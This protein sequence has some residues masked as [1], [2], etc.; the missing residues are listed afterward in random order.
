MWVKIIF[1]HTFLLMAQ[2]WMIFKKSLFFVI[3]SCFL[4][5]D[6][7]WFILIM[8]P[9]RTKGDILFQS[10]FFFCFRF[11]FSAKLVRTITFLSFQIGQLYLVCGC[12]TIRRWVAYRNDLL[13]SLTFD[14]KV[15]Y[16]FFKQYLF[17]MWA[18]DYKAVCR[19]P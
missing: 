9:L 5:S 18:H 2:Y 13:G 16:M 6:N 19:I 11:C 14:L 10:D 3:I 17:G 4:T 1:E 12:I 7:G 15:K 8:S